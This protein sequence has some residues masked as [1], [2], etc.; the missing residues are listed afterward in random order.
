MFDLNTSFLFVKLKKCFKFVG[1]VQLFC[2]FY[3]Y[4][5]IKNQEEHN[6]EI[7]NYPI[8]C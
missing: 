7:I 5:L 1:V 2:K 3:V 8:L 6:A 4:F